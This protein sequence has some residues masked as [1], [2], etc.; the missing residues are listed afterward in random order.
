MSQVLVV[1]AGGRLYALPSGSVREI[2]S[3]PVV[4][5][6]P[7]AAADVRGLANLRGQLF[8]V[9]DLAHRLTG[10]PS[11]SMEP[12][13]V[14]LAVD[15][16]S[17]GLLVDDVREVMPVEEFGESTP[18]GGSEGKLIAGMGHFGESVVLLV[19]VQELVRQALA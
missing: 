11:T 4:T 16:K 17:L 7:G 14:V 13:V 1:E 12:D 10:T 18:M 8:A 9:L 3:M 5:R 19:N 15:G 6:L 2:T